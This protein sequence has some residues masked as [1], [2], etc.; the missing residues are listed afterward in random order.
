MAGQR[1]R[2][3]VLSSKKPRSLRD[4]N[5][6]E[7]MIWHESHVDYDVVMEK[8]YMMPLLLEMVQSYSRLLERRMQHPA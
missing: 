4:G 8:V 1:T 6:L 7:L 2:M 5:S 3:S